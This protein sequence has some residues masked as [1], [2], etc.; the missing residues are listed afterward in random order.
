MKGFTWAAVSVF[1]AALTGVVHHKGELPS[2]DGYATVQC[3]TCHE[4][5]RLKN[6]LA[7][8]NT[9]SSEGGPVRRRVS[10]G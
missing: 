3:L 1:A 2:L 6:R 9:R 8:Q 10:P 4:P 5:G 7:A